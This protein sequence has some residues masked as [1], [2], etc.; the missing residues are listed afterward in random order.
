M[1][2]SFLSIFF[3]ISAQ[4]LVDM[5]NA[6]YTNVWTDMD[7]PGSGYELKVQRAYNSRSLFNGL[8]GFGWCSEFETSLE[9]T[10]EG[11]IK[12]R[13]C[14]SGV[15][16]VYSPKEI[17]PAEVNSTIDKI[18][19]ALRAERKVGLNEDYIKSLRQEL[20]EDADLRM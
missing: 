13:E 17:S 4:A 10:A 19:S 2:N 6:N 12:V 1:L 14:G 7:V 15:E 9:I 11:N 18:V 3:S 16:V 5:K 20:L 8:F